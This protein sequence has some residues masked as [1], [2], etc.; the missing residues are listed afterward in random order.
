MKKDLKII[1]QKEQE[2]NRIDKVLMG[3]DII[4]DLNITRNQLQEFIK[5]GN[6]R[7]VY[8]NIRNISYKI[9]VCDIF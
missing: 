8:D 7:E 4:K 9:K 5:S 1:I 6:L 3:S 2:K